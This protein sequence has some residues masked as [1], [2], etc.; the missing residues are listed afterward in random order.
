[1]DESQLMP[2]GKRIDGVHGR[3]FSHREPVFMAASILTLDRSYCATVVDVSATGA[4]LSGC[5]DVA[6][7][8]DLW[9]KVGCLDRLVTVAW[10]EGELCG[11]TFDDQLDHDDLIHL[12]CEAR[13]TLVMRLAPEERLAAQDW[14][15]GLRR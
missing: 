4:R 15:N 11:V 2:F 12:R 8:E 10:C 9:I 14:I 1:M 3:R 6:P 5:G 13:N 7:G